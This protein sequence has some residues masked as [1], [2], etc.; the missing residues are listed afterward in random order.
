MLCRLD[1]REPDQFLLDV[2]LKPF[3]VGVE[4]GGMISSLK[5]TSSS[6][7]RKRSSSYEEAGEEMREM[8]MGTKDRWDEEKSILTNAQ[9]SKNLAGK[10]IPLSDEL[11]KEDWYKI[12]EKRTRRLKRVKVVGAGDGI[13]SI[14]EKGLAEAFEKFKN[15]R[16]DE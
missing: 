12:I 5:S 13:T 8:I 1:N 16:S 14:C 4:E 9:S 3:D 7:K 2:S 6:W 10:P 15:L 11:A